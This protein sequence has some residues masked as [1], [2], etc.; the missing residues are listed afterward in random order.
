MQLQSFGR[1]QF[2]QEGAVKAITFFSEVGLVMY[3]ILHIT[4]TGRSFLKIEKNG[5]FY[6]EVRN[7]I[8]DLPP[9]EQLKMAL[10]QVDE[11]QEII[12]GINRELLQSQQ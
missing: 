12:K 2:S 5:N 4:S 7:I 9:I 3:E 6:K 11:L 8:R 1:I 10:E